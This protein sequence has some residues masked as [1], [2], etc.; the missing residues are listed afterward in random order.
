MTF[1]SLVITI[2]L[3]LIAR[4]LWRIFHLLESA[5]HLWVSMRNLDEERR[6][7]IAHHR[8]RNI[9]DDLK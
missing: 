3:L 4:A 9:D 7:N 2:A 8:G 1:E 6:A 5:G